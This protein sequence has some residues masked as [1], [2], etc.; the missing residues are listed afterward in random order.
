[1]KKRQFLASL[2]I[3]LLCLSLT[4]ELSLSR[5]S[6]PFYRN[7]INSHRQYTLAF[8]GSHAFSYLEAQC[9]FGPRPP[10][11]ENLTRCGDYIISI[12]LQFGWAIENQ[13]WS[14]L[15]TSLRNI[16]AGAINNPQLVLL[17]HYDTRPIADQ[18]SDPVNRSKPILGANDGASGVAA[19]LELA[20]ILP[21][22]VQDSVVLLFVDAEDSGNINDW[23]WIVGSTHF[24]NSLTTFQKDQIE[25][26]ILLDMMADADLQLKREMFS[27]PSLVN[28]VWQLAAD[29]NYDDL[30]LNI[31]GYSLIDDHRPFLDA[32]IPAIDIIDFDYPYWHTL[33]DTPDKCHPASLEAVGR[34]V[35][36]FV[37]EQ[38]ESPTD[39]QSTT[40]SGD[41]LLL[42]IPVILILGLM[43]IIL[44]ANFYR[45]TRIKSENKI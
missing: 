29:L 24:V 5:I 20:A 28:T 32:G 7:T 41:P 3:F 18:E 8:N 9:N 36:A 34:V 42:L 37:L 2:A 30:F 26:A 4:M 38:L 11:S 19:L 27:T 44:L 15:N 22:S 14:F 13:S 45:K 6:I 25:A 33:Q 16:I 23:P 17:A 21:P 35:E 43:I 39:Y 10:G 1:M 40:T 12:L 31:S